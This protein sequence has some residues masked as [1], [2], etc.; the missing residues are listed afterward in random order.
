MYMMILIEDLDDYHNDKT[1]AMHAS[2]RAIDMQ[3]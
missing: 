3:P 2:H 1:S